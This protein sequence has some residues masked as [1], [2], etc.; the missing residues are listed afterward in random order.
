MVK[1]KVIDIPVL[2]IE[3]AVSIVEKFNK[4][5]KGK[6]ENKDALAKVMGYSSAN[7]GA[8]IVKLAD[9]R[10]FGLMEK[11]GDLQL[12][13]LAKKIAFSLDTRKREFILEAIRNV[14]LFSKLIGLIGTNIE[15]A[16]M[17]M[18]LVNAGIPRVDALENQKKIKKIYK[19]FAQYITNSE[20]MP[21]TNELS[22]SITDSF[23]PDNNQILADIKALQNDVYRANLTSDGISLIIP[24]EQ[25]KIDLVRFLLDRLEKEIKEKTKV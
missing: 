20:T 17:E 5:L 7:N 15:D 2:Q 3:E 13:E 22:G 12:T 16:D 1:R 23:I 18:Q 8:F 19:N 14:P 21:K 9:M 10:K 11:S 4:E 24:K 25:S 6:A